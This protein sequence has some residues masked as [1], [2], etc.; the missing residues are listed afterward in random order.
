MSIIPYIG[1]HA[2]SNNEA[3]GTSAPTAGKWRVGDICWNISP[4]SGDPVGWICVTAGSPGTWEPI[5]FASPVN[6]YY[7]T[8]A[9]AEG[10][11]SKGDIYLNT[12]PS[13]GGPT[14]WV[15]VTSGSPGTWKAIGYVSPVGV[16]YGTS[17]PAEG[18]YS[19]GD[20]CWNTSPS[21][22][23]VTGWVC[24]TAGSPGTW[25]PIGFASP[26]NV[27][28]G[29]AAPTEG[30]YSRGD[31]CWNTSPSAGVEPGWVCV[32]SGSPGTWKAMAV[33]SS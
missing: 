25:Q 10:T 13:S 18:T 22:G 27:Y 9:P 21:S 1:R 19:K 14:G 26:I 3:Y 17:A 16:Y 4:G 28:Y 7:G 29:T 24:V 5:G 15:C 2:E 20:I 31:I 30:T 6:I 8:S 23:G 33:L 11:Y 32:S 12:S